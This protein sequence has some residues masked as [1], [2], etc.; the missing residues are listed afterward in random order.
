MTTHQKYD[1]AV[2]D[3]AALGAPVDYMKRVSQKYWINESII[4]KSN[5]S[6]VPALN[7]MWLSED[8]VDGLDDVKL[9]V[10]GIPAAAI[11][12]LVHETTH[13]F[14]DIASNDPKISEII[15]EGIKYYEDASL[16]T[17]EKVSDPETVFH[18]A[19]A[20]YAANRIATWYS[21]HAWIARW[22]AKLKQ[23]TDKPRTA[24]QIDRISK[25]LDKI[26]TTYNKEISAKKFGYQYVK[27]SGSKGQVGVAKDI[28][29]KIAGYIDK[30]MLEGKIQDSFD[31]DKSLVAALNEARKLLSIQAASARSQPGRATR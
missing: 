22:T 5:D 26:R 7:M 15:R 16:S 8:T 24:A 1:E 19:A 2:A 20:E 4:D 27:S 13:A 23:K 9:D 3:L 14:F 12:N 21:A 18:E 17:G 11:L 6:V 29:N 25:N 31:N 30:F 10:G 28:S